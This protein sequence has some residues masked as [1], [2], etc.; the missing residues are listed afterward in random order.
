M[1]ASCGGR[2]EDAGDGPLPPERT[3][4]PPPDEEEEAPAVAEPTTAEPSTAEPSTADDYEEPP[5]PYEEPSAIVERAL[6][7]L[8]KY[9][10][11]CHGRPSD[12]NAEPGPLEFTDDVDRMVALG[13]I[14][15]F[16][17]GASPL[18][19]VMADG[20]MPPRGVVPRPTESEITAI[21]EFIEN[22]LLWP[23]Q[24]PVP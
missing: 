12:A 23:E 22:P 9:C 24:P 1:S 7:V 10:G 14:V 16:D 3:V 4:A 20:S 11:A 8:D 19:Q 6:V 18:V 5:I 15:P 17:G 13:I 21:D 2:S